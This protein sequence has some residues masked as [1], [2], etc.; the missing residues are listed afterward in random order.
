MAEIG[1]PLELT[2]TPRSTSEPPQA[3]F[4]FVATDA[5]VL[6]IDARSFDAKVVLARLG[7]DGS[8]LARADGGGIGW[9]ARLVVNAR[10]GERLRLGTALSQPVAGRVV[11]EVSVGEAPLPT[12]FALGEANARF[13]AECGRVAQ[14]R[15]D[16]LSAAASYHE[17]GQGFFHLAL[18]ADSQQAYQACLPLAEQAGHALLITLAQGHLGAVAVRFDRPAEARDLL[19]AACDGAVAEGQV[20][21]EMFCQ[22]NLADACLRLGDLARAR[23]ACER[24][25][26][27]AREIKDRANEASMLSQS[28]ALAV[29]SGDAATA[30]S[31]HDQA[32]RA[33]ESLGDPNRLAQVLATQAQFHQRRG[34]LDDA[35]RVLVA[36][37]EQATLPAIRAAALGELG[38]VRRQQGRWK[39]ASELYRQVLDTA[40][41][42][43]DEGL[44][45][46][47]L[48]SLGLVEGQT[49]DADASKAHLEQALAM[50]AGGGD[51]GASVRLLVDL[52]NLR[53]ESGDFAEARGYLDQSRTI[54]DEAASDELSLLVL[55]QLALFESRDPERL[56]KGVAH[57]EAMLALARKTGLR[58]DE[59]AALSLLAWLR[60]VQGRNDEAA[61]VVSQAVTA[62]RDTA[63]H[64]EAAALSTQ[65]DIALARRDL[66]TARTALMASR[67]LLDDL[68]LGELG[69]EGASLARS[70]W[71]YAQFAE[72]EQDV[73]ALASS[74]PD[75]ADR[76]AVIAEGFVAAGRAQGRA[77][78]EGIAE[79]RS[80]RRDARTV[81]LRSARRQLL[82]DRETALDAQAAARR[83][84]GSAADVQALRE[85]AHQLAVEADAVLDELRSRAPQEAGLD[86]PLDVPANRVQEELLAEGD[87][88]VQYAEG[89]D[90]L[91]AYVL[92]PR[93]LT[94]HDLGLRTE[95]DALVAAYLGDVSDPARLAGPGSIARSGGA[96]WRALLQPLLPTLPADQVVQLFLVPN[97]RLAGLPFEALVTA[98][99][100]TAKA[101]SE[102]AFVIDRYE[103][104]YVPSVAVL[105][106]LAAV[107]ARV[108][109][110]HML[111][112]ADPVV[113]AEETASASVPRQRLESAS[114]VRLPG[115]R[116]EALAIVDLLHEAVGAARR[117]VPPTLPAT[118][119]GGHVGTDLVDVYLGADA[120]VSRLHEDPRRYS[121]IH[122]AAHG[123]IDSSDPMRSGLVLSPAGEDDGFLSVP[124]VLELDL[125][126]D[127]VVLSACDT[128]RGAVRRGEGVQSVARAFM[129]AGARGVIA[130]LWQVDDRETEAAMRSLYKDFHP[131]GVGSAE[132]LRRARLELRNAPADASGF[133]GTG[134][135]KLLPGSPAR[136]SEAA[137]GRVLP[138]HPYFWAPFVA[139][140][141]GR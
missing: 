37:L 66:P 126:A 102:L 2:L 64:L 14:A 86:A 131:G 73:V 19:L 27:I 137:A 48:A 6:T 96:A 71:N 127:L 35:E 61:K 89:Q 75:A 59:A 56:D 119:R 7:D 88:L 42:L 34:E 68:P 10:A 53:F 94:W 20:P 138:G 90:R 45:S 118:E 74:L 29:L 104:T 65:I 28:A 11:V 130:T 16:G 52:A 140:G 57:A 49:G 109:E 15:G 60:H 122:L 63:P 136:E 79:Q 139:I 46:A 91:Y 5:G 3:E 81:E 72:L 101:F 36:A 39:E 116:A 32:R 125:D 98:G 51:A 124:E 133:A 69:I 93:S 25:L 33:A 67:K 84:K 97:P 40:R 95:I 121:V 134:R 54:A 128:A 24:A 47:A 108:G 41:E 26:T 70:G 105:S 44:Q 18:Y 38:K 112:L 111:V 17:A 76:A 8:V 55:H 120:T 58:N 135:G 77:L 123:V 100:A 82:A 106:L 21:F 43:G 103:V 129:Y 13:Y 80:G 22:S 99:S 50:H 110:P 83:A 141:S 92:T 1:R 107:P 132:A 4:T 12:G 117:D 30:R 114:W 23:P 9:N 113:P 78:L 31:L 87:V 115:T 85:R 62:S